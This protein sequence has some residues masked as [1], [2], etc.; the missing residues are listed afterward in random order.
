M[1]NP[2][3]NQ[4]VAKSAANVVAGQAVQTN[5]VAQDITAQVETKLVTLNETKFNFRSTKVASDQKDADGKVIEVDWKRPTFK[6]GLPLLTVQ[7]I[8]AALASNEQKTIDLIIESVNEPIINRA[9][10][11]INDAVDVN[12]AVD[13]NDSEQFQIDLN[14]LSFAAIANLPKSERGAGIAKEVWGAFVADYIAVMQTPKAVAL[15]PDKKAR[16]VDVLGKHGILLGGKFNQVKSRKDVVGQML[17]FLDIWLQATDNGEE[18]YACYEHLVSKGKA[19]LQ[20]E[21]FDDL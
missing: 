3:T 6:Q 4:A 17:G 14:K 11:I 18:H 16:S 9:R 2:V 20:A 1:E 19:I 13:L 21:N 12:P 15:F 7:G 8:L 5:P 10:G